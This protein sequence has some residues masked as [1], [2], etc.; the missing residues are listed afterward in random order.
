MNDF[1]QILMAGI[2]SLGF[3][4]LYNVRG[5][6]LLV[7]GFGGIIAWSIYLFLGLYIESEAIRYFAITVFITIYTEIFARLLK[8]PTTT[9]LVAAIITIIP[10]GSLYLTMSSAIQ[11]L[12]QDFASYAVKTAS[13]ALAIALG[14]MVVS[15]VIKAI[16]KKR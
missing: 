15:A 12:W 3:A 8:T 6:K 13:L 9:F 10:G 7:V 1:L 11:G 4:V 5:T 2:A 16:F 14:I